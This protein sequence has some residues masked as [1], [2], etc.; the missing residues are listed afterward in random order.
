MAL[1]DLTAEEI[2]DVQRKRVRDSQ[3]M[4]QGR[5]IDYPACG[6][7]DGLGCDWVSPNDNPA[8]WFCP[9]HGD[10]DNAYPWHREGQACPLDEWGYEEED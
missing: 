6:H 8:L 2:G 3:E 5:C 10:E 9:N 7:A 1:F 4:S